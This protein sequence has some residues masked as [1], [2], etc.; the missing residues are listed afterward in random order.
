MILRTFQ[1]KIKKKKEKEKEKEKEE[2]GI[3]RVGSPRRVPICD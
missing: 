1:K 2:V 3:D